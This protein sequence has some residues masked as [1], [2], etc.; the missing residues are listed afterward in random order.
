MTAILSIPAITHVA[1]SARVQTVDRDR[2]CRYYRLLNPFDEVTG[3][4]VLVN[5]SFNVRGE[6]VV[7]TPAATDRCFRRL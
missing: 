3:W 6:Q 2:H 7:C 4:A 5:E 1:D